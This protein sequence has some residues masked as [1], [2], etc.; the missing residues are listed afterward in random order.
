M[1]ESGLQRKRYQEDDQREN[2]QIGV[3]QDQYPCVIQTPL[4]AQA[5]AGFG[6]PPS[7]DEKCCEL[8][9]RAVQTFNVRE[10]RQQ[11]TRDERSKRERDATHE[12][13]L[14]QPKDGKKGRH[15]SYNCRRNRLTGDQ[16]HL[17]ERLCI[18][19]AQYTALGDDGRHVLCRSHIERR[20]AD[21]HPVRRE[22]LA[23]VV[24]YFF[25]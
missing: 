2:H 23:A 6:H 8:P 24:G 3:E 5:A 20:I 9:G 19:C 17:L 25:C 14:P 7:G 13:L 22:L 4:A 11:K 1:C 16:F 12:R 15:D 18:R 10:A 21:A